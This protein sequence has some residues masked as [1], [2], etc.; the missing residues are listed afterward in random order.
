M[1]ELSALLTSPD[2]TFLPAAPLAPPDASAPAFPTVEA[3]AAALATI[4]ALPAPAVAAAAA[5]ASSRGGEPRVQPDGGLD[6]PWSL[7]SLSL[8]LKGTLLLFITSTL[9]ARAVFG[10]K[11]PNSQSLTR[12][13]T[14][15]K[16]GLGLFD[17][18]LLAA[19]RGT[20][21]LLARRG[22]DLAAAA[23]AFRSRVVGESLSGTVR[24]RLI[25][26]KLAPP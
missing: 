24:L 5:A 23:A 2:G 21:G 17:L 25:L 11:A 16:L 7:I 14:L 3:A 10:V 26:R 8:S 12:L 19:M 6:S 20:T 13:S 1:F 18:A 4:A 15:Q 22:A 9:S